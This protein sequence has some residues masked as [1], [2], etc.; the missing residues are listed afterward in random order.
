MCFLNGYYQPFFK[1]KIKIRHLSVCVCERESFVMCMF[2]GLLGKKVKTE[3][4][5]SL[6]TKPNQ[7]TTSVLIPHIH[8]KNLIYIL[9]HSFSFSSFKKLLFFPF[10]SL[11]LLSF[12]G[13]GLSLF[14]PL[15]ITSSVSA[16]IYIY[17]EEYIY[18]YIE[19]IISS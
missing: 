12:W 17:C 13:R 3:P 16:Y 11:C 7:I 5:I 19:I 2:P 15:P 6:K 14:S 4:F 9:L 1:Q 8:Q 10:P 18:V